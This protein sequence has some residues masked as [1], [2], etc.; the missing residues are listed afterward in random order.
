[1]EVRRDE[2]KFSCGADVQTSFRLFLS[3]E[4]SRPVCLSYLLSDLCPSKPDLILCGLPLQIRHTCILFIR[5]WY[6][7]FLRDI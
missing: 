2:Q 6:M 4:I 1:M 5:G 7:D 3:D